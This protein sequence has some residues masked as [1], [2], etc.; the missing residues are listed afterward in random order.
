MNELNLKTVVIGKIASE[1]LKAAKCEVVNV[2]TELVEKAKTNKA[3]F[4]LKHPDKD[5]SI[6]V[7]NVTLLRQKKGKKEISVLATWITIDKE[8]NLSMDSAL[9][10]LL[11][12][13]KAQNL[14]EMIGKIV[15]TEADEQGY[16][17]LKAY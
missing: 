15:E 9:A 14:A 3:V 11:R 6:K 17:V 12:F 13:Y 5:E 10:Q 2:D 8:N 7:S 16:L 1:R 4:Y